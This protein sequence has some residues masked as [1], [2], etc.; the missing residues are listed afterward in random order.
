MIIS[1][2]FY[3]D[4]PYKGVAVEG[5]INTNLFGFA[6]KLVP[7]E[8]GYTFLEKVIK[9]CRCRS[10]TV[11]EKNDQL[12]KAYTSEDYKNYC[13]TFGLTPFSTNK[14][15]QDRLFKDPSY[16]FTPVFDDTAV[17]TA[18]VEETGAT[19]QPTEDA[20]R[21]AWETE[22]KSILK[23]MIDFFSEFSY[24]PSP[25]FISSLAGVKDSVA[26]TVNYFK[27]QDHEHAAEI[28]DKVKSTEYRNLC[29]DLKRFVTGNVN[30]RLKIYF[31]APGSGKTTQALSEA[32]SCIVCAS[33]MIPKLLMTDFGF[34]EHGEAQFA[35]SKLWKAMEEGKKIVFD[36]I[37]MLPF[38]SLRFLQ[39]I[40]DNKGFIDYEG[41][42]I[43]IKPGFEIIGTMNL[44]LGSMVMPLPEPL[45]DRCASIEEYTLD[46]SKLFKA[47]TAPKAAVE[48][49]YSTES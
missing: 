27:V 11:A 17:A 20:A 46:E 3:I 34:K 10:F 30:S 8:P 31:G 39:G 13:T 22:Y 2:T 44:N 45:V 26:Y 24:K 49:D 37:N 36:E 15:I 5:T 42:R 43:D 16:T 23:R 12:I 40:T 25:R 19:A 14:E 18:E 35:P 47:L 7:G 48:L 28:E 41:T 33:D 4:Q 32:D 1:N 9:I 29:K 38:E 21:K 6:Q